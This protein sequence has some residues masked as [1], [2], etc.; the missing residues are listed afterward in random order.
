[1]RGGNRR[2]ASLLS[3][4][5]RAGLARPKLTLGVWLA[6][7]G[8]L[9]LLGLGVEHRLETAAIYIDGTPSHLA[10][11]L[12]ERGFGNDDFLV[13]MLRGPAAGIER[14]GSALARRLQGNPRVTVI[15]PWTGTGTVRGLHPSPDVAALVVNVLRR[16]GDGFL[17]ILPPVTNAVASVVRAPVHADVSSAAT[18]TQGMTRQAEDVAA[19]SQKIV[20]P[21]LAIVL[22]IVFGTPVSALIPG[23]MGGATVA[24][25]RGILALLMGT[26]PLDS[27]APDLVG[28]MGLALGVDY[29]LLTISRFREEVRAGK[30]YTEAAE[31]TVLTTG[32][33]VIFAGCA[34]LLAMLVAAQVLP[35]AIVVSAAI[36]I[37]IT[38][39]FS[40]FSALLVVPAMLVLAG[41]Y[42][43]RWAI[44]RRDPDKLGFAARMA[45]RFTK[46]SALV[47]ALVLLPLLVA[48]AA[49]FGVK[50]GPPSVGLL[51]PSEPDRQQYEA[52]SNTLGQGWGGSLN[53]I[54]N[55]GSSPITEPSTL[56][57]LARFEQRV[58]HD[59]GVETVAGIETIYRSLQPLGSFA[60]GLHRAAKGASTLRS[61]SGQARDGA[62]LLQQGLQAADGGART[63]QEGTAT[64]YEGGRR[65]ANGSLSADAGA[66]Q[67]AAGAGAVESGVRRLHS[68]AQKLAD[69]LQ[70]GASQLDAQQ[71]AVGSMERNIAKALAALGAMTAGKQDPR[72]RET[73]EAVQQVGAALTGQDPATGKPDP[74][75]AGVSTGLALGR[76]ELT[77]AVAD[78]SKGARSSAELLAGVRRLH[79]GSERLAGGIASLSSGGSSLAGGLGQLTSGSDRLSSGIATLDGRSGQLVS[80]LTKLETGAASLAQGL[81][82]GGG[83]QDVPAHVPVPDPPGRSSSDTGGFSSSAGGSSSDTGGS[84]ARASGSSS[85]S[86]TDSSSFSAGGSSPGGHGRPADPP[87]SESGLG[88]L[89]H[90]SPGFFR[91][92]YIYLAAIDGAPAKSR[93][94]AQLLV[95]LA[96]G[97]HM[98]RIEVIPTTGPLSPATGRTRSRLEGYARE[99]AASTH[100]QVVVGGP[101]ATLEEYNAVMRSR[102]PFAIVALALMTLL[103]LV[104]V[105]RSLIVPLAAIVLNIITVGATFGLMALLFNNQ[106]LGGPGYID[107]ISVGSI[108]TVAFGL[109]I[110]YEVFVLARIR[111]EYLRLGNSEEAILG[112]LAHTARVVTGAAAIMITVFLTFALSQFVSIRDFGVALAIAVAIDAFLIRMLVLPAIMRMLGDRCWWLP[113]WLDRILPRLDIEGALPPRPVAS[114]KRGVGPARVGRAEA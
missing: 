109:S 113:A 71:A 32:R 57:A 3:G 1:M 24:A 97:G 62:G 105:L 88:T 14:Q 15:S 86:T 30:S 104:P 111:E 66:R 68:G 92:G 59:P 42:L 103:V 53:V 21:V 99:L 39:V 79:S 108:V 83:S 54:V 7:V 27:L 95:D 40:V 16:P 96:A 41:P 28:M 91:S 61:G 44:V 81:G 102:V 43:E 10:K 94:Q 51:P 76:H 26:V 18:V 46:R 56:Q 17:A 58:E 93:R 31:L 72:Y 70:V 35:G 112:G 49:A 9:A 106:T 60:S 85:S 37:A 107:A 29:S 73:L 19:S 89:Q 8:A 20:I 4:F 38:S 101:A 48:C 55:G 12:E 63:L 114:P 98:A 80:G 2:R 77:E 69:G 5:A 47:V 6:V 74:T 25:S 64:A 45:Q 33:A 67:V 36:A 52:V 78:A 34:L 84:S 65:L 50:T 82:A 13:V 110:D 22:L 100:T 23:L 87:A 90:T 11:E 75:F